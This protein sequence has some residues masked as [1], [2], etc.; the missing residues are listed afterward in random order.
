MKAI[1][2]SEETQRVLN[3]SAT[4]VEYTSYSTD[5]VKLQ[6][7][8][9]PCDTINFCW[10][11]EPILGQR[12]IFLVSISKYGNDCT[13]SKYGQYCTAGIETKRNGSPDIKYRLQPVSPYF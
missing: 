7:R 13:Y 10:Y 8:L 6:Y 3:Q 5:T 11:A 9:N 4:Q 12:G 1:N 2:Q